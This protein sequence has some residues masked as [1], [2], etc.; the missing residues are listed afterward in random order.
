MK[1][2][3]RRIILGAVSVVAGLSVAVWACLLD[4]ESAGSVLFWELWALFALT[5]GILAYKSVEI[6]DRL[7]VSASVM[8]MF[9]AGLAFPLSE[10]TDTAAFPMTMLAFVGFVSSGDISGRRV[11]Q[12]AVNFGQIAFAAF[13]AGSTADVALSI[14]AEGSGALP[15]TLNTWLVEGSSA[16]VFVAVLVA[17]LAASIVYTISNVAMVRSMVL[18]GFGRRSLIPW[19]RTRPAV[20]AQTALGTIGAMLGAV[21]AFGPSITLAFLVGTV[22]VISHLVFTSHARLR[23]TQEAMLRGFVKILEARDLY[24]RGHTERVAEFAL[25]IG[26]ELGFS[27]AQLARMRLAALIHDVGKLAV[28]TPIM[29]KQ[30]S[31]TEIEFREMRVAT[32]KVDDLLSQVSFLE[33]MVQICSGVHPRGTGEDFGQNGHRHNETPTLEQSVLAVADAF[34]AMTSTRSYRMAMPQ[35]R[36]LAQVESSNDPLFLPEVTAA[37]KQALERLGG[38][39]GPPESAPVREAANRG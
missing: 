32:H 26:T 4:G 9:T 12:M 22:Y 2:K 23:A 29:R 3:H 24:T 1:L 8:A 16:A 20:V 19:S 39:Y 6:D 18:I 35:S 31:L 36:A 21:L 38:S 28:P 30:G 14:L 34:D 17:G 27:S 15:D 5:F 7:Q 37:L 10:L 13:L 33:P 25:S 11:F